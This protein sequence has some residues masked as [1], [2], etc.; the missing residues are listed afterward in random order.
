MFYACFIDIRIYRKREHIIKRLLKNKK[1]KLY[2][3]C[4]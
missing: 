2:L 3:H 1:K 4:L